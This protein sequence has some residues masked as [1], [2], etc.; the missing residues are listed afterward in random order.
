MYKNI[1]SNYSAWHKLGAAINNFEIPRLKRD[2]YLL[3]VGLG[4][5]VE[6]ILENVLYVYH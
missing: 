6:Y 3:L 1:D 5:V 2:N 4:T